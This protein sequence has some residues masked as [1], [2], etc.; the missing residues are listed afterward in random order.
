M[1]AVFCHVA[2]IRALKHPISFVLKSHFDSYTENEV[3]C[4]IYNKVRDNFVMIKFIKPSSRGKVN[5]LLR[6]KINALYKLNLSSIQTG[7]ED[8][9]ILITIHSSESHGLTSDSRSWWES[10][11]PE[12][13]P[14]GVVAAGSRAATIWVAPWLSH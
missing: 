7:P 10:R 11:L 2:Y 5:L 1:G 6:K 14:T 3:I 9:H 13:P 4:T 8:A 12:I